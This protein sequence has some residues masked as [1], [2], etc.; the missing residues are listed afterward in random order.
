MGAW[1]GRLPLHLQRGGLRETYFGG[2][3]SLKCLRAD[4]QR[5]LQALNHSEHPANL[6]C[7]TEPMSS[8]EP[9]L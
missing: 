2:S 6:R 7:M 9:T 1:L 8:Q 4:L 5:K 3:R